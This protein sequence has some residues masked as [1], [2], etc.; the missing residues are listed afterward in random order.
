M[1]TDIFSVSTAVTVAQN[2]VFHINFQIVTILAI[3]ALIIFIIG[4]SELEWIVIKLKIDKKM[5]IVLRA[6]TLCGG[7]LVLIYTCYNTSIDLNGWSINDSFE[8]YGWIYTN[9]K[10][11][12]SY[13]NIAPKGYDKADKWRGYV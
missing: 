8:K 5:K 4:Y 3:T 9:T 7:I 12:K 11:I 2:Y 6:V 13:W 10:L 1:I